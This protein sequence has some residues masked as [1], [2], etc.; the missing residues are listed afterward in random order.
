MLAADN[1]LFRR[2]RRCATAAGGIGSLAADAAREVKGIVTHKVWIL[3]D[4]DI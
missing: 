2:R 1:L 4:K 3:H